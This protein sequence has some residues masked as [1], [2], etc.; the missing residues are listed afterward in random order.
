MGKLRYNFRNF[1]YFKKNNLL[2]YSE[3]IRENMVIAHKE[4]ANPLFSSIEDI[5][6]PL[7]NDLLVPFVDLIYLLDLQIENI[8]VNSCSLPV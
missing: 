3:L 6:L 7:S 2:V 8:E 5:K 4:N 1:A